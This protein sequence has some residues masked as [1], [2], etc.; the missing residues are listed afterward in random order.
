MPPHTYKTCP[1]MNPAR[2]S[3]KEATAWA[4]SSGC[5]MRLTG[6]ASTILFVF[7]ASGGLP[8][9]NNSVAIGPGPTALTVTPW[10]AVS[11]AQVLV[12]PSN[13]ALVAE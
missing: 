3:S 6:I 7:G 2:S 12:M 13:P 4:I 11:K 5:P 8:E 10:L 1:V 9:V